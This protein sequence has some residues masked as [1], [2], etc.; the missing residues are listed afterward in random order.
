MAYSLEAV[1]PNFDSW[2]NII[3]PP[4][5]DDSLIANRGWEYAVND[6]DYMWGTG[7]VPCHSEQNELPTT[8]VQQPPTPST[9]ETDSK[10]L[11]KIRGRNIKVQDPIPSKN[12]Q[13]PRELLLPVCERWQTRRAHP[14]PEAMSPT[15]KERQGPICKSIRQN[16]TVQKTTKRHMATENRGA[17]CQC[18]IDEHG[19]R[20]LRPGRTHRERNPTGRLLRRKRGA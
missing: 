11:P 14:L 9:Q 20:L 7:E 13:T 15:P 12:P 6:F 19:R 5:N 1:D 8:A 3:N 10:T 17:N 4:Y 2:V 16:T 18:Q